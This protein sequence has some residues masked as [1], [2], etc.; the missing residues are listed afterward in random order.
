MTAPSNIIELHPLSYERA[1]TLYWRHF[2]RCQQSEDGCESD[3]LCV[4]GVW[5]AMQALNASGGV[6]AAPKPRRS[7]GK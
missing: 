3:Q 4:T 5:L 2:Q 1:L 7:R 6:P